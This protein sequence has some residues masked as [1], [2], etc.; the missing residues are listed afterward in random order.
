MGCIFIPLAWDF[1]SIKKKMSDYYGEY[2]FSS[3]YVA[4][5]ISKCQKLS[6]EF[7][8]SSPHGAYLISIIKHLT[9]IIKP[10]KVFVPSRGISNLNA[11]KVIVNFYEFVFVPSRGI[12][13]LNEFSV[14]FRRDVDNRF[15]SPPGAYLISMNSVLHSEWMWIIGFRPLPG[16]I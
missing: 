9:A 2:L 10:L 6:E 8:F 16:H 12:S 3:P 11:D 13:N 1:F 5:L 7:M 14:K 4:F 15:S